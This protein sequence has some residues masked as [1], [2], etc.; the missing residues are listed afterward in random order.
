MRLLTASE[1]AEQLQVPRS[2]LYSAARSGAFPSVRVG[3]YVRF[4]S[5]DVTA[6][7]EAHR[8]GNTTDDSATTG[9]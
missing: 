7:I 3:R 5:R 2:W 4:D 9:G 1:V 8:P 6:W